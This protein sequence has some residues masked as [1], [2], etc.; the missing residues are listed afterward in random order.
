MCMLKRDFYV[1]YTSL[2]INQFL[3]ID[4]FLYTQS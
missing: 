2:D 3:D 4:D 1:K